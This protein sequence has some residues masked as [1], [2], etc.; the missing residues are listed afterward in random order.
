MER[1]HTATVEA[2]TFGGLNPQ[3][4]SL[5]HSAIP[6]QYHTATLS[7]AQAQKSISVPM[8][9]GTELSLTLGMSVKWLIKGSY[10]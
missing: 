4:H 7:C 1:F 2:A 8:R 3:A 5:N 10:N 6:M 9:T